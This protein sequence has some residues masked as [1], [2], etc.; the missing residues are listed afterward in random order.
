VTIPLKTAADFKADIYNILPT[1]NDQVDPVGELSQVIL[2][3]VAV[4]AE[5]LNDT[6]RNLGLAIADP[7]SLADGSNF[8]DIADALAAS[9][10]VV[11]EVGSPSR[12][13]LTLRRSQ[14]PATGASLPRGWPFGSVVDGA[15]ASVTF[16]TLERATITPANYNAVTRAYET[17]V[18]AQ[19]IT[20]GEQT[21]AGANRI[22]RFLRPADFDSVTNLTRASGGRNSQNNQE[23]AITR[24]L[25]VQAGNASSIAAWEVFIRAFNLGIE[26]F[27]YHLNPERGSDEPGALDLFCGFS[28]SGDATT[29]VVQYI[30]LG[31]LILLPKQPLIEVTSVIN[32]AT[33]ATYTEGTDYEVVLD[34]GSV[35]GLAGIRFITGGSAPAIGGYVTVTYSYSSKIAALQTQAETQQYKRIGQSPLFRLFTDIPLSITAT[36]TPLSGYVAGP[37]IDAAEEAIQELA[38]TSWR[39][40]APVQASDIQA[41]VR[42]IVGVDNFV[43]TTLARRGFGGVSDLTFEQGERGTL[44]E[45]DLVIT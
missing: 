14:V 19:S 43:I 10:G 16:V 44:D 24:R 27:S 35:T 11:R 6:A 1:I 32:T 15:G 40:G 17:T 28:G 25:A 34:D 4:I 37:L 13:T 39:S 42:A 9:E 3:P 18:L 30:A 31:Q 21:N 33:A 2:D 38:R 7:G 5:S 12:V 8:D 29:S 20:T 45:A 41:V 36:L 26:G 23:L 22:R